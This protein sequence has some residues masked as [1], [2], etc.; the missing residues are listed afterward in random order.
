MT[1]CND[2]NDSNDCDMMT[3]IPFDRYDALRAVAI[4][5]DTR[6]TLRYSYRPCNVGF[7]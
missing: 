7:S 6:Y 2:S 4:R 1:A 5:S 3:H